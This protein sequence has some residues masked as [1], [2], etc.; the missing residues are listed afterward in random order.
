MIVGSRYIAGSRSSSSSPTS[1]RLV[2]TDL[3][4]VL[5]AGT[6]F[7]PVD[8]FEVGLEDLGVDF[9]VDDLTP[10]SLAAADFVP[11]FEADFVVGSIL[12]LMAVVGL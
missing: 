12:G 2:D 6:V 3:A 8:R 11:A 7:A 10:E 1:R 4:F 5:E 9:S